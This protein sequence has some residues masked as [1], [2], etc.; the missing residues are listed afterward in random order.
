MPQQN[1]DEKI[2]I[3]FLI[4]FLNYVHDGFDQI[5]TIKKKV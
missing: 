2:L 5:K 3:Q 4:A 1:K